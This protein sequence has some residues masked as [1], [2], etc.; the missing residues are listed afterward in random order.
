VALFARLSIVRKLVVLVVA[1]LMATGTTGLLAVI[2]VSAVSTDAAGI[3]LLNEVD[4]RFTQLHA[5][6]VA[7]RAAVSEWNVEPNIAADQTAAAAT[8]VNDAINALGASELPVLD[9]VGRTR[10]ALVDSRGPNVSQE[11][12]V[13]FG[14]VKA[15]LSA[16][17]GI[18]GELVNKARPDR[19]AAAQSLAE[20]RQR[21][22]TVDKAAAALRARIDAEGR[23]FRADASNTTS[24]IV[25][26]LMTVTVLA[27]LL[28]VAITVP[29]GRSLVGPVRRVRSVLEALAS[30]DLTRRAGVVGRD[31]IAEMAGSLDI[32]LGSMQDSVRAVARSAESL[33]ESSQ[34]LSNV[35]TEIT[36]AATRTNVEVVDASAVSDNVARHVTSL[37]AGADQMGNSIREIARS[38][39]EA[40]TVASGAAQEAVG[41]NE[42]VERLATSSTEIGKVLTLITSIAAQTN[43]LALNATIEAS[44]AGDAGK[45]FAVVAS[46][47]MELAQETAKATEDIRQRIDAIQADVGAAA[48]AIN[49]MST[50]VGEINHHQSAIANA[51]EEQAATTAEM[52]R[53]VGEAADGAK[54]IAG[55]LADVAGATATTKR[56]I[57]TVDGAVCELATMSDDLRM[58]VNRFRY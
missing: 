42:K 14:V 37:A 15:D 19:P 13:E 57:D 34:S 16:L 4:H 22:Q 3:R 10:Q 2:G 1:G 25:L 40:A 48:E 24:H 8:A 11:F 31:E 44:R 23:V 26:T 55:N 20:I 49:R 21:D 53:N 36:G 50:T 47:V 29:V 17:C 18:A 45:G 9:S 56:G 41:A 28:Y 38:A 5:S 51:V 39:G 30:G 46:E 35:S 27:A 32:A 52:S 58:L 7:L 54:R 6:R 12:P 43:L 33:A